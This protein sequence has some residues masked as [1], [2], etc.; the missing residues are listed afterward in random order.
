MDIHSFCVSPQSV[1]IGKDVERFRVRHCCHS[2]VRDPSITVYTKTRRSRLFTKHGQLNYAALL[3][4]VVTVLV[5]RVH[6]TPF[7]SL[8]L[9]YISAPKT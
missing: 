1:T 8:G 4:R 6:E 5:G 3:G 7:Y 2:V 9:L